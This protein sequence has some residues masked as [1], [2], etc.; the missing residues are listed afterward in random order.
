MSID[1]AAVVAE[2]QVTQGRI[3]LAPLLEP[4]IPKHLPLP[5]RPGYSRDAADENA[6][7][8]HRHAFDLGFGDAPAREVTVDVHS[9]KAIDQ[10]TAG[11]LDLLQL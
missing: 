5:S 10:R 1:A 6:E 7:N 2:C 4:G 11:D 9:G 8:G 3:P